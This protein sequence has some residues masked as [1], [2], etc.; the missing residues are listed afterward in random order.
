VN[1]LYHVWGNKINTGKGEGEGKEKKLASRSPNIM[2]VGR[3][4][5]ESL[6]E[7]KQFSG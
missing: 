1:W 4:E 2:V 5:E 6:T 3:T 7:K